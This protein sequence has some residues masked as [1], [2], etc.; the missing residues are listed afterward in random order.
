MIGNSTLAP[1]ETVR[2]CQRQDIASGAQPQGTET[3][4]RAWAG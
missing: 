4:F 3:A 2:K 1:A